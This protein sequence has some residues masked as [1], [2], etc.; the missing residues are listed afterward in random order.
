MARSALLNVMVQAATKA[1]RSL[2]RDFG[3][4]EQLQVSM[5]GPGDF[6]TNA[7]H[8]A[9]K[10]LREELTRVRPTYGLLMEE[11]GEIEGKDSQHRWIVDPLDGTTN[12]MHAVPMFAVS[13]GL[14]RDGEIV[15]GVVFNPVMNELF[16]AEKGAGAFLN[17]RRIRVAQRRDFT[18]AVITCGVPHHGRG[19]HPTFLKELAPVMADAAGIRR[20]GAA[21]VD[22]CWVAAG[23][24]DGFFERGL[25]P[26]DVAAGMLIVSEAGGFV[27][28]Y[29]GRKSA[30]YADTIIAANPDIH[31]ELSTRIAKA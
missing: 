12:F 8:R 28:D 22:L 27:S 3:E 5:K 2:V 24:F 26:W 1:G 30:L 21:S 11:S 7:D 10:I 16:V 25:S 29:S 18:Q 31:R 6:V 17:D 14:E 9:E 19:N 23:R 4:V 13:V 20:T 15:A